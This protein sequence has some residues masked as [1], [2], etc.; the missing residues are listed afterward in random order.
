RRRV[1]ASSHPGTFPASGVKLVRLRQAEMNTACV[2]SSASA[3]VATDRSATVYTSRGQRS[4]A[5]ASAASSPAARCGPT[6]AASTSCMG[7]VSHMAEARRVGAV[8]TVTS[9]HFRESAGRGDRQEHLVDAVGDLTV[10]L[11]DVHLDDPRVLGHGGL[12]LQEHLAL[13]HDDPEV[14]AL[15]GLQLGAV[16]LHGLLRGDGGARH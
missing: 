8:T 14:L 12:V 10:A 7:R 15:G 6:S 3:W 1:M 2:M 16:G 13:L 11:V 9:L 5:S 4:Y